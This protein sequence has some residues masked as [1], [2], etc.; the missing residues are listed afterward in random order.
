MRTIKIE[1]RILKSGLAVVLAVILVVLWLLV[2][3][4]GGVDNPA[5]A[6]D[7]ASTSATNPVFQDEE[8]VGPSEISAPAAPR[9]GINFGLC[10]YDTIQEAV[11]AAVSGDT[12]QV[13]EGIYEESVEIGSKNLTIAGEYNSTCGFITGG[14]TTID[15][16]GLP[17]ETLVIITDSLVTLRKLSIIDGNSAI[18]GGG[19]YLSDGAEVF[20]DYVNITDN[21]ASY[22]G[23]VYLEAG[24]VMTGYASLISDNAAKFL[25]GGAYVEGTLNL[26]A[27]TIV[28]GNEAPDGGGIA[29]IDG[30]VTVDLS[31]V[32]SNQATGGLGKGGGIYATGS[33]VLDFRNNAS[34]N[35]NS[36]IDGGG[37][38]ADGAAVDLLIAFF[39]NN[40]ATQH[41][42]G[43]YLTGDAT[44][45]GTAVRIGGEGSIL[46]NDANSGSGGGIYAITSTVNLTGTQIYGNFAQIKGGGIYADNSVTNLYTV[47]VGGPNENKHNTLGF[48]GHY[49]AGICLTNSSAA[50]LNGSVISSNVFSTTGLARGGGIYIEGGSTVLLENDSRVENHSPGSA[51]DHYGAGIYANNATV[52]LNDSRVISNTTHWQGG[53]ILA[54][55]GSTINLENNASVKDNFATAGEGG[56]I[57]ADGSIVNINIGFIYDNKADQDGGG[58]YLT[59]GSILDGSGVR[60]GGEGAILGNDA[61]NGSGGGIFAISSTIDLDG[62]Q[63]Y[64]N[65]A[66]GSG[67]GIYA[68]N[69]VV[70]LRSVQVGGLVDNHHNIL[71]I[72][73]NSG[74]GMLL[75]GASGVGYTLWTRVS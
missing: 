43:L 49:G 51:Y 16:S 56:G 45:D 13:S 26:V 3:P 71:G 36:A 59:N 42:G 12:I 6:Y 9:V 23:G 30:V 37:V 52:T 19:I 38:Y 14:L 72:N 8:D 10:A 40:Q 17:G 20:L 58:L 69:S 34:V 64:A 15:G 50:T 65:L 2:L 7:E 73:G 32:Q 74:A 33:S 27:T 29:A 48:S 39:Y 35:E 1:A 67:G 11:D 61:L 24:T 68:D 60:I 44:L 54:I 47:T 28:Q 63:V 5:L 53:G 22:G 4:A 31:N 66:G 41:G 25:G 21:D 55:N 46:G 62:S 75:T 70:D 57:Y 18:F